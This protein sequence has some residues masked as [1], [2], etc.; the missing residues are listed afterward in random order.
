VFG[1]FEG[2]GVSTCPPPWT[3]TPTDSPVTEQPAVANGVAFVGTADGTVLAYAARGCSAPFSACQPIWSDD[4]GS[5]ITGA[6]TVSE[7][8]LYVG[9]SD[10]RL[11]AYGVRPPG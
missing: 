5:E 7:G 4:V 2:C 8:R 3:G 10:G 9:T 11:I 1:A 6:P